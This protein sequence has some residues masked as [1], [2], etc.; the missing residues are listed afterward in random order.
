MGEGR[1]SWARGGARGCCCARRVDDD[2]D[3][4]SDYNNNNDSDHILA[5]DSA[6]G[7]RLIIT[8]ILN[9]LGSTRIIYWRK[10][11]QEYQRGP[12]SRA[13]GHLVVP[14][15]RR[16]G[17]RR[18]ACPAAAAG[19]LRRRRARVDALS[20]S[21]A[22]LSLSDHATAAVAPRRCS[23]PAATA[24]P[25][26]P[27]RLPPVPSKSLC[28]CVCVCVCVRACVCA[29]IA[30]APRRPSRYPPPPATPPP[31]RSAPLPAP[32]SKNKQ[33][34]QEERKHQSG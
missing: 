27:R 26:R 7:D 30:A 11:R 2:P 31:P 18:P 15:P 34:K 22:A 23:N 16:A 32:R 4:D 14:A 3:D 10:T 6:D 25:S 33:N 29:Y 17:G 9:L 1:G 24:P 21:A 28:V 19:L 8:S 12:G 20:P 13:G 5:Q